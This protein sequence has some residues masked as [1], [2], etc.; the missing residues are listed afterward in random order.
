MLAPSLGALSPAGGRA[1]I[2]LDPGWSGSRR[3][4]STMRSHRARTVL[5]AAVAVALPLA[6]QEKKP[7][8]SPPAQAE[9]T[10]GGATITVDYSSPRVRGR[11]IFGSLVPYDKVWRT[12]A[13]AATTLTT[14]GDLMIGELHVPA[15]TYTL[16]T[17]PG[18]SE[19]QLIVNRQT[20]QWGTQ[21]D[22]SQDLGRVAMEVSSLAEPREEM[23][24]AIRPGEGH[25]GTLAIEWASTAA[26]VSI[27]AH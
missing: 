7:P 23:T 9:A 19:W 15:G 12:G 16:Y 8:L 27:L 5:V 2:R 13:N 11:E 1:R 6:A 14:D 3:G 24:I 10:I 25:R 18:E 22:E 4:E 26:T 17:L 21:Y 20:G